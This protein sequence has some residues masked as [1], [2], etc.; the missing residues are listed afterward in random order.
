MDLNYFNNLLQHIVATHT[1]SSEDPKVDQSNIQLIEY[2]RNECIKL[3][4]SCSTMEIVN[5]P[6]K[7]NLLV[8][9]GP[10]TKGGLLLSGHSDTV[11]CDA[12]KWDNDPFGLWDDKSYFYGLGVIDMKGFFAH[13]LTAYK[14]LLEENQNSLSHPLYVLATVDEETSMIGAK[15]F[16]QECTI[17]PDAVVIGEPTSLVPVFQHKGYLAYRIKVEGVSCHSSNPDLGVN[18]ITI[19][20]QIITVLLQLAEEL[21]TNYPDPSFEVPYP[22]LNIGA[23]HGGDAPNRVCSSCEILLDIRPT[24]KTDP[25]MLENKLKDSIKN[26]TGDNFSRVTIEELYPGIPPFATD[27][28]SQLIALTQKLSGNQAVAV[29]YSTEASFLSKL[30]C[31][32]VILGAGD[33][34]NAHQI[35]EKLPKDE[36]SRLNLILKGLIKH[37]CQ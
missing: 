30:N 15:T 26:A 17:K 18:A 33:I 5:S 13:V 16:A 9:F 6:K 8:R 28:Q 37:Y 36:I 4:G 24:G 27:P 23:I 7:L 34:A 12:S 20:N 21:K 32:V 35:N 22:T 14:D 10:D 25:A 2:L 1:I 31:P 3:Q 11:P 29:N 19:M